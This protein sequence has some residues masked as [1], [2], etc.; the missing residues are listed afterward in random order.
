MTS[1]RLDELLINIYYR[2]LLYEISAFIKTI[3]SVW[4]RDEIPAVFFFSEK[5]S[6]QF[7]ECVLH[8][9]ANEYLWSGHAI[10]HLLTILDYNNTRA[11]IK[12]F[13]LHPTCIRISLLTCLKNR[14]RIVLLVGVKLI[15]FLVFPWKWKVYIMRILVC[16]VICEFW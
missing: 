15:I 12:N 5:I 3:D 2:I 7:S 10:F 14:N 16:G 11:H 6:L 9:Y 8:V 4:R 13:I 1:K